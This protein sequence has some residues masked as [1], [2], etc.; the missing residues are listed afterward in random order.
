MSLRPHFKFGRK[1]APTFRVLASMLS[2]GALLF[3]TA[4]LAQTPPGPQLLSGNSAGSTPSSTTGSEGNFFLDTSTGKVWGP[5]ASGVWPTSTG[6]LTPGAQGQIPGSNTS[7][8]ACTGCIGEVISSSIA[9]GSGVSLTTGTPAQIISISLTPGH[10]QCNAAAQFNGGA[11]TTVNTLAA[12]IST[13]TADINETQF[14]FFVIA[15]GNGTAVFATQVDHSY[16]VPTLNVYLS[17]TTT[18]YLNEYGS[19]ATSTL[20]GYGSLSCLRVQ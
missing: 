12:K 9:A 5:K 1:T 13:T 3:V 18:Y 6:G 20:K 2:V 11:T 4:A 17:T 8:A 7:A 19:F 14:G 15:W 16:S 10:W